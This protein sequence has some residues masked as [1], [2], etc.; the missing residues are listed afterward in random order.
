MPAVRRS[1][2]MSFH[3]NMQ[4]VFPFKCLK[5]QSA[6]KGDFLMHTLQM[7]YQRIFVFKHSFAFMALKR[8]ISFVN[9]W[10]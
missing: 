10:K 2:D 8:V 7:P 9:T 1:A 3:V 5:T 4:R 6:T